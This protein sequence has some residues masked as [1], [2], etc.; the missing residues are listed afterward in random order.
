[1][2]VTFMAEAVGLGLLAGAPVHAQHQGHDNHIITPASDRPATH[3]PIA[4]VTEQPKLDGA[5]NAGALQPAQPVGAPTAQQI[6]HHLSGVTDGGR[7][8]QSEPGLPGTGHHSTGGHMMSGA[9]GPYPNSR[10][11]SGTAW[12]PDTSLHPGISMSAGRWMLMGHALLN[13]VYDWQGGPRGDEKLF[14]SGM[15][16]GMAQRRFRDGSALQ[17]RAM[18]SPDPLMGKRGYPLHLA[19][20]ETANGKDPLIDRQH[21]HDLFMELS[22]SYSLKLSKKASLFVYGG[23][24][25]EPAF[26]PPAFMH[27]VSIMD[28]PEAP[29]THHWLDSTHITFGVATVGLVL[30][31]FKIEA[32]RFHGREPNQNRYDIET[33]PLDSTAVRLSFNPTPELALQASWARIKSPEQLAPKENQT[34]WSTSALY[35]RRLGPDS[36]FSTTFAWGRRTGE[37]RSFNAFALE[38]AVGVETWTLFGRFENT[39]NNELLLVNGD[40]GPTFNVGKVALGFVRDFRVL[41][42]VKFGVG[43][44]ASFNFVPRGLDA[45]Y[46]GDSNGAMAFGRIKIE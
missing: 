45:F 22:A 27:R 24:P 1:M 21:P 19:S 13:G 5:G 10:E 34:R 42:H 7:S 26:G 29:I 31:R 17:F 15:L 32:S 44:L 33:G 18:L 16:M 3:P 38:S 37:H 23:L 6:S 28:S 36:W 20:G 43:G 4:V 2:K 40:H 14:A 11:A 12:Q 25:G 9:L 39:A 35:T 46:A 8:P 30:D 41:D